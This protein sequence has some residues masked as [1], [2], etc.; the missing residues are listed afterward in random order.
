MLDLGILFNSSKQQGDFGL[1]LG[2]A[3][4]EQARLKADMQF[5]RSQ[6]EFQRKLLEF[7]EEGRRA[8]RLE[9]M[10]KMAQEKRLEPLKIQ[11]LQQDLVEQQ[12]RIQKQV[13][14]LEI[15]EA[16]FNLQKAQ[17]VADYLVNVKDSR[18]LK[19][20][21]AALLKLG[22]LAEPIRS[23]GEAQG[24]K[25][26]SK[27]EQ[28]RLTAK[29]ERDYQDKV[30]KEEHA[31]QRYLQD[32]N[33][34][35]SQN[36]FFLQQEQN[37]KNRELDYQRGLQKEERDFQR[38]EA[39]NL[40][41][42]ALKLGPQT[43]VNI[44]NQQPVARADGG[45]VESG[46]PA[47]VGENGPELIVPNQDV[48]VMNEQQVAQGMTPEQVS[49]ESL[50]RDMQNKKSEYQQM[51]ATAPPETKGIAVEAAA[52]ESM[53]DVAQAAKEAKD[54]RKLWFDDAGKFKANN[55][56]SFDTG[57]FLG[58]I[59]T[60]EANLASTAMEF[61]I[62]AITRLETGAAMAKEEIANTKARFMPKYLDSEEIV[63]LKLDMY[64]RMLDGTLNLIQKGRNPG[65]KPTFKAD[66]FEK[67]LRQREA[68]VNEFKKQFPD[69]PIQD[70]IEYG[71]YIGEIE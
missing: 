21:N 3:K 29:D 16:Q 20:A 12:G 46:Q 25:L 15:T 9:A 28:A 35:A 47:L 58:R 23:V 39:L 33:L 6:Q 34:T 36:L 10:F 68:F 27:I 43:N 60:D 63:H 38:A 24:L 62:Q 45:L 70:A 56:M 67:I 19:Q 69:A 30:R 51:L 18:S 17:V 59:G 26:G 22:I 4:T 61:G 13:S 40:Q 53:L 1:A 49:H 50:L 64:D 37:Q 5:R 41:K 2:R 11:K 66:K 8:Q 54:L 55:T 7:Q 42:S 52:K 71:I 44:T 31:Q 57:T 65:D 48:T 14:D 32:N